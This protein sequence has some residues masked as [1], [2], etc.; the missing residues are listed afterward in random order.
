MARIPVEKKSNNN[1]IWLLLILLVVA[2]L[3]WW[4]VEANDDDD[5]VADTPVVATQTEPMG[6]ETIG[7]MTIAAILANP[8]QYYGQDGF[9]GMVEVA[10]PLT[11]RGFWITDDAGN[12]MLAIIIDQ[13]RE[14]PIDINPGQ[15]LRIT[16]GTVRNPSDVAN[17]P[18]DALDADTKAAMQGQQAVLV[19]NE[20]NI[21][22]AQPA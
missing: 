20:A 19:V 5:V 9:T 21:D 14:Q 8:T 1:W 22:I 12:R 3:I 16:G 11:D 13:P 18:G 4:L 7:A 2:L 6:A 15:T 17:L 10:G